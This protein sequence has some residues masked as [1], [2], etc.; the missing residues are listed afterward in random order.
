MTEQSR[1]LNY[2][3]FVQMLG[4]QEVRHQID[5]RRMESIVREQA[6]ELEKLQPKKTQKPPRKGANGR[7]DA[8]P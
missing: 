4:Q 7:A 3:D 6:E 1:P 8:S 5:M 2:Q